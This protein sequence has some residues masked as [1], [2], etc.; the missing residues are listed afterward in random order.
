MMRFDM[1]SWW[2]GSQPLSR[3]KSKLKTIFSDICIKD[4][5]FVSFDSFNP[6]NWF[7]GKYAYA[8]NINGLIRYLLFSVTGAGNNWD[9]CAKSRTFCQ[10]WFESANNAKQ[11]ARQHNTSLS[12]SI[13]P[14]ILWKHFNA[15][16]EETNLH[17]Q[18]NDCCWLISPS[19]GHKL[20]EIKAKEHVTSIVLFLR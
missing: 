12:F 13:S 15:K 19:N 9:D 10:S 8:R 14:N 1:A 16:W 11:Y 2:S 17:I 6:I 4:L 7:E 18:L 20:S 3:G 5:I